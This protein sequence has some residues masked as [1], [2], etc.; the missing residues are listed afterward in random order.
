[1]QQGLPDWDPLPGNVDLLVG[2]LPSATMH[3]KVGIEVKSRTH[4]H[5]LGETPYDIFK[6]AALRRVSGVEATY[7]VVAATLT[8][9]SS[10]EP[11]AALFNTPLG[12]S[13]DWH[14]LYFIQEW[15]SEWAALL[16]DS[17]GKP[18]RVPRLLP[19]EL[20]CIE[21][22]PAFPGWEIRALRVEN[23]V[24]EWWLV[25]GADGW[26]THLDPEPWEGGPRQIA[27]DDLRPTD[28]PPPD[29]E[30]GEIH[31]FAL[32]IDGYA[33]EGNRSNCARLANNAGQRWDRTGELPSEL[34]ALRSCL[35]FRATTRTSQRLRLR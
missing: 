29:S 3:P 22:V 18:Q 14:L 34:R 7:L 6:M 20:V 1:M 12:A 31:R 24:T 27:D 30:E 35:F 10:S 28:V 13:E 23:Q 15:R 8:A 4:S 19:L 21:E 32:S 5:K 26:P 25:F 17:S 16:A 11:G 2:E 33:R 9:F